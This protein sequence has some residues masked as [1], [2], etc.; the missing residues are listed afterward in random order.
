VKRSEWSDK[1]LE[2]LLRQM[3][4]IQ[5]HRN[6]HDIYQNLS[7]KKRKKTLWLISGL[8]AATALLLF[9]ILM[10]K[11]MDTHLSSSDR[12]AQ[13]H[14]ASD[15]KASTLSVKR[16]SS[17]TPKN[18]ESSSKEKPLLGNAKQSQSQDA[19]LKTAVYEDELGDGTVLT[20]WI[21]DN[22]AQILVPVSTIVHGTKDKT[23]L[24]LFN[25][26]MSS[27]KEEEWGLSDYY[28]MNATFKLDQDNSIVV[29]VPTN[30][31]YGQ[32]SA[33]ETNFINIVKKDVAADSH[34][35]KI[36]LTTNG[37]PGITFGNYG[38][39]SEINIDS[40]TNHA[41]FFYYP[42]GKKLPFLVPS[43]TKYKN[44]QAALEAMGTDHPD[45]GLKPSLPS[46]LHFKE[47]IINNHILNLTL[48][49]SSTLQND[50]STMHSL[51]A[52][53]LTAKEF[54]AEKVM[55]ENAQIASIGPFDLS[56]EIKVPIAPNLRLT[57]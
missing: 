37:Q 31:P 33:N 12:S 40:E 14:M 35:K 38:E 8:A 20:Y 51:E 28:P 10:P 22:E 41:Y 56:K 17:I 27:L 32:G 54:G 47:A 25:E 11:L 4:K 16:D 52:I 29:D 42:N 50:N 34:I 48:T 1:Q 55:F 3:P 45:G 5:D 57:Q 6:P 21:P 46:T 2:D 53:L 43:T 9:I 19:S 39:M 24:T 7:F 26:N 49:D 18:E 15:Q 13:N 36:K 44:I 23:W 30:H